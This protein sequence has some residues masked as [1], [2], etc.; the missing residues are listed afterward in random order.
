M[1]W[2]PYFALSS[3]PYLDEFTSHQELHN[4][5]TLKYVPRGI[6]DGIFTEILGSS[7]FTV[8]LFTIPNIWSLDTH[9][10]MD[11]V[12]S[13][14]PSNHSIEFYEV[15]KKKMSFSREN[16]T[17]TEDHST[18]EKHAMKDKYVFPQLQNQS[19]YL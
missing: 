14:Y 12:I 7:M 10:Q 9:Q 8:A 19:T 3:V 16:V 6:Q 17:G 2:H 5:V 15:I 1:L 13:I 11:K 18:N 4:N